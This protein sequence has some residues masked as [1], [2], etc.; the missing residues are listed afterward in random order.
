M[1]KVSVPD[2]WD[3]MSRHARSAYIHTAFAAQEEKHPMNNV[4][5]AVGMDMAEIDILHAEP[6]EQRGFLESL[7]AAL[8]G[9]D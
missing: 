9:L 7:F 6:E 1:S 2:N 3:N 8:F 4:Y 5:S